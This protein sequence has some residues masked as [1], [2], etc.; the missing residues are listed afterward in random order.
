MQSYEQIIL[1]GR[2]IGIELIQGTSDDH[3]IYRNH[4]SDDSRSSVQSV[5]LNKLIAI[6]SS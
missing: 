2:F 5:T 6:I 1:Y 4:L 3:K